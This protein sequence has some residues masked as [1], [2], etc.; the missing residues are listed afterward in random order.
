MDYKYIEQLLERYWECQTT[1]EEEAILR[2]FF[3][4][5]SGEGNDQS[6]SDIPASLLPY[7]DLFRVE[8]EMGNE[9]L[10]KDFDER[11][12]AMLKNE[13]KSSEKAASAPKLRA[14]TITFAQRLHPL[15]RAAAIVA[16]VLSIG[17]AAQQGFQRDETE[18]PVYA[19]EV[20]PVDTVNLLTD[21]SDNTQPN[22]AILATS[23][24][25]S[26]S[27]AHP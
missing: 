27:I 10:G 18:E 12:L 17:M 16:I 1:L 5:S 22:E 8:E 21:I 3:N 15:W 11:V 13:A 2:A 24:T 23:G 20:M 9:H 26:L 19:Q 14:Q 4:R 25:D 7:C 6:L